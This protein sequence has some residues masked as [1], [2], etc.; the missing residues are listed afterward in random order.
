MSAMNYLG[1]DPGG[2]NSFGWAC[3]RVGESDHSLDLVTGLSSNAA[4]AID[5]AS[6]AATRAPVSVGIDAPLFWIAT[7]DRSADVR[8]R[9]LV[10][11]AGGHSST[12]AHVNSLRGAC[13]VQGV[14]AA[15]IAALRWPSA[16]ITEAHPKALYCIDLAAKEFITRNLPEAPTD[17][18][19]D[20]ALAAFS[21]WAAAER[22]PSWHDLVEEETTPFF[23]SGQVVSYWFP[24]KSA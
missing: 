2:L 22:F 11:A 3:L 4:D 20:A 19:R 16:V 6:R 5:S 10:K 24:C 12:V 1:L 14:L 21:A 18:E 8:V 9:K 15:Q 23:P 13:L 7:G 17:H